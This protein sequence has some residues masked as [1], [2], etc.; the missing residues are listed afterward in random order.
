MRLL[1]VRTRQLQEFIGDAIPPYAILSHTWGE[2]E[3]SFEDLSDPEHTKK[4]GH[5]KIEGCCQQAIVEGF[6]FVWV[7]TCCIDKRSSAELSEAINSMFEWYGKAVICYVYLIDVPYV[8]DPEDAYYL[9]DSKWF[10]RG[11]TLQEL[12]APPE[13]KFFDAKWSMIFNVDKLGF[14][15]E[16]SRIYGPLIKG[17]TGIEGW[18]NYSFLRGP[19]IRDLNSVPVATRLSWASRRKTTRV[20]DMAYSLLGLLNINMPLLYGEGHKAFLRLQEEFLK[21]YDDPTILCSGFRMNRLEITNIRESFGTPGCLA[22]TPLLFSGFRGFRLYKDHF[23]QDRTSRLGWNVTPHGLYTEL[24]IVQFDTRN[25]IYIG[26]TDSSHNDRPLAIPLLRKNFSDIYVLVPSFGPFLLSY[27]ERRR[28]PKNLKSRTI[29][30]QSYEYHHP[31]IVNNSF[32]ELR[33]DLKALYEN[34]FALDSIYPNTDTLR[35][36]CVMRRSEIQFFES[37]LMVIV[38]QRERRDALYIRLTRPIWWFWNNQGQGGYKAQISSCPYGKR[39]AAAQVWDAGRRARERKFAKVPRLDWRQ[40]MPIRNRGR[41]DYISSEWTFREQRLFPWSNSNEDVKYEEYHPALDN[42]NNL[43]RAPARQRKTE[44]TKQPIISSI[45]SASVSDKSSNASELLSSSGSSSQISGAPSQGSIYADLAQPYS[46]VQYPEGLRTVFTQRPAFRTF[47]QSVE[48]LA[49]PP[50]TLAIAIKSLTEK[51]DNFANQLGN[52]YSRKGDMRS[53]EGAVKLAMVRSQLT[54]EYTVRTGIR[55]P[56]WFYGEH[57]MTLRKHEDRFAGVFSERQGR[58]PGPSN[59][60]CACGRNS[61]QT[62]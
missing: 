62:A 32:R 37:T 41:R 45:N 42:V 1:N 10:T 2:D 15:W 23:Y 11:W 57:N 39:L 48:Y 38:L 47:K 58:L 18:H 19:N 20:E 26:I 6:E 36:G 52:I 8:E 28:Y 61:G 4:L 31:I 34:G 21:R 29:C 44:A 46:D 53:L 43:A 27:M 14:H 25:N 30:L 40:V 50:S 16:L 12:I 7:D 51:L 55:I 5:K 33:V 59:P 60:A 54:S 49:K 22:P 17:I 13:L 24:P 35:D 56:N 9:R 3:V